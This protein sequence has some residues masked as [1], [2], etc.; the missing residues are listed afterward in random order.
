MQ[1]IELPERPNW[2]ERAEADGFNFHTIGGE[3]YWDER[4]AYRFTLQ[5][6]EQDLEDPSDELHAMCLAFVDEAVRDERVLTDLGIPASAWDAVRE[7]W[8]RQDAS[9][10]GRL[11]FSYDGSGPAKL[12]E[13]NAD[14]PTSCFETG[15]F[16]W[17]WLTDLI[18][19]G[20]LPAD[21]DQFNSLQ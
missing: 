7:S 2:R 14:T 3:R 21:A 15:W 10:Y 12:L 16:Q 17:H 19:S 11:D 20:Q 5:Q 8:Q 18:E 13:Y 4:A 9:I 6:I 1:R